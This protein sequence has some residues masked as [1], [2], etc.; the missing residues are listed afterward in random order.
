MKENHT[1][2][3]TETGDAGEENKD[4]KQG[5]DQGRVDAKR[6]AEQFVPEV[7]RLASTVAYALSYGI[8]FGLGFG[9]AVATEVVPETVKKAVRRGNNEGRDAAR[10][11]VQDDEIDL[12]AE[13]GTGSA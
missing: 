10:N 6:A 7:E 12:A 8:G 1:P 4:P 5:F 9:L 2:F 3:E 11:V 13:P